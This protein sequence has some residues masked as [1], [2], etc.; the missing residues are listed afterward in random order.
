MFIMYLYLCYWYIDNHT[1]I[2]YCLSYDTQFERSQVFI[3]N[4]FCK[5]MFRL[6]SKNRLWNYSDS[7]S[8]M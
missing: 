8:L 3:T 2:Y 7:F 1:D 5:V 6:L 4:Y